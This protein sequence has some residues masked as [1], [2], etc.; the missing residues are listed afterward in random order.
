MGLE[1]TYLKIIKA[2]YDKATANMI[3]SGEKLNTFF[4]ISR[5]KYGCPVLPLLFD[6]VLEIPATAIRQEK[7]K[8][9]IGKKK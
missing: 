9:P 4:L 6:I 5:T 8:H 1:G 7:N 3:L 2:I